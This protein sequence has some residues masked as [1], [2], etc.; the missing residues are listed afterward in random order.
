MR[1]KKLFHDKAQLGRS[2]VQSRGKVYRHVESIENTDKFKMSLQLI[3]IQ[4]HCI[5]IS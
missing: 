5:K 1:V 2:V 3:F 4:T